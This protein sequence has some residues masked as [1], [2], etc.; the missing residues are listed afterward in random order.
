MKGLVL[1]AGRGRRL[2][3]LTGAR[4]K[5]LLTVAPQTTI[6]DVALSSL[7]AVGVTEVAA[8]VGFGAEEIART[9]KAIEAEHGIALTL[10][11]NDRAETWNNAYSLWLGTDWMDVD[12]IVV[13][14]DTVHPP[15]VERALLGAPAAGRK[16]L[17]AVDTVKRLSAEEMKVILSAGDVTRIDKSIPP[18]EADGE[19]IGV[20][21]VRPAAVVAL[22]AALET[23]WTTDPSQ[24]YEDGFQVLVDLGHRLAGVAIGTVEWVEVD[25]PADLERAREIACRY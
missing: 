5:T 23:T 13:N 15:S 2:G 8:V 3:D 10:I 20:A 24:Y 14:G 17:L 25:T 12:T 9:H 18:D 4:P 11:P 6:L 19:Y 21:L 22:R 7:S 16:I 1:A